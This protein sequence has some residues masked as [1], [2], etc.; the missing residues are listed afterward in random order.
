MLSRLT[1]LTF[2]L[3]LAI[4][5][6]ALAQ[7]CPQNPSR[8]PDD[9]SETS[10]W[11]P[12]CSKNALEIIDGSLGEAEALG[13]GVDTTVQSIL[14]IVR[15][16]ESG[17]AKPDYASITV[18]SG[19]LTYG[20]YQFDSKSGELHD[21]LAQYMSRGGAY[22]SALRPYVSSMAHGRMPHDQNLKN[23]LRKA[24]NDP[25]MQ[26][27]QDDFFVEHHLKN[28]MQKAADAGIRSPL[29]VALFVDIQTNGGI[30][31]V[32]KTAR[33]QVPQIKTAGDE[34]RFIQAMLDAREARY[35]KLA[36]HGYG[37]YLRGWIARN[38][39][40]RSMLRNNDIGLEDKIRLPHIGESFCGGNHA[41]AR[42]F[43][44]YMASLDQN[45]EGANEVA[46]KFP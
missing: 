35:R 40:F 5:A 6:A 16:E 9:I 36:R 24:A 25:I 12:T 11:C 1:I 17:S 14:N 4:P 27:T 38:N 13:Q 15:S 43:G 7:E 32:M 8:L 31:S 22:S 3:A 33:R 29:G 19:G 23:I 28:S 45:R 2:T 10:A 20:A 41:D 46:I 21:M 30:D 34:T 39:D 18:D 42:A 37:K 44:L 26:Q